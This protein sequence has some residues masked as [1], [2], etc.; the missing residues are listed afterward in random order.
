MVVE[1][2][3]REKD[4]IEEFEKAQDTFEVVEKR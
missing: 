2:R 3:E 4:Y 1:R